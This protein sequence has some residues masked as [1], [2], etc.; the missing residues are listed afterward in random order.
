MKTKTKSKPMPSLSGDAAAE[1]FVDKA[2]LSDHDLSGFA[3]K[4]FE[5]AAKSA[6]LTMR[7]PD[8]LLQA[9][10][11]KAQSK[12]MPYTRYVRLLLENDVGIQAR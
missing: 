2:D 12:G 9:L 8:E 6:S 5:F 3:P 11:A 10:K 1:A 4:R 7:L